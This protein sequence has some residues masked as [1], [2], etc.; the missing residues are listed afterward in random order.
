MTLVQGDTTT[1]MTGSMVAFYSG[2]RVG[3][4]EAGLR[5]YNNQAPFPEEV[6]RR[7]VSIFADD[8]FA[9]TE[10]CKLALLREGIEERRIVVTGNTVVDA[11]L[12]TM[13]KIKRA[14]PNLGDL[15]RVVAK[16][17]KVVLITGHRRESFG[18]GFR[19]ICEAVRNL[20]R[21]FPSVLF[22]YPVH[23]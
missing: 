8:H 18:Q 16:A 19:N 17:E 3:H 6:N 2:S 1:A 5:T 21:D 7:L 20:A 4:V 22:V 23:L 15:E 9:P 14:P 10:R 11:L 12:L 13:E